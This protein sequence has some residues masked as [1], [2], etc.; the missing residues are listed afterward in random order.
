ME[1]QK[2]VAASESPARLSP[3]FLT[4]MKGQLQGALGDQERCLQDLL[5]ANVLPPEALESIRLS[6]VQ[7]ESLIE[8]INQMQSEVSLG[9]SS[10]ESGDVKFEQIDAELMN[11]ART[12][13]AISGNVGYPL[14]ADKS[15]P[16]LD[17]AIRQAKDELKCSQLSL[18]SK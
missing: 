17:A 6:N 9:A 16:A 8:T 4:K 2:E 14:S 18:V 15:N 10:S 13:V 11:H 12:L 7:L 5:L 3:R 1:D